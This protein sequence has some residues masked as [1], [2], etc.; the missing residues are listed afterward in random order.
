MAQR[1]AGQH[2]GT[3]Q[4]VLWWRN[5]Q[6]AAMQTGCREIE[7]R[8]CALG[9]L[10]AV[11]RCPCKP[12]SWS[13][14]GPGSGSV[15]GWPCVQER[16]RLMPASMRPLERHGLNENAVRNGNP[17]WRRWN[18]GIVD[19]CTWELSVYVGTSLVN[20]DERAA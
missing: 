12:W 15:E 10:L 4:R 1:A 14:G 16:L 2:Y 3:Q 18:N 13:G 11:I 8:S 19:V 9:A 20:A 5:G 6:D 17:G 7:R